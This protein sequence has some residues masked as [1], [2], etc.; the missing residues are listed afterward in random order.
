M[1]RVLVNGGR[2]RLANG[3]L[4]M[5]ASGD[6]C[7]CGG[8]CSCTA[9]DG[10]A[11]CAYR[12][13]FSGITISPWDW[14]D[15]GTY[16]RDIGTPNAGPHIV[17]EATVVG[18]DICRVFRDWTYCVVSESASGDVSVRGQAGIT[19]LEIGG[20]RYLV[21]SLFVSVDGSVSFAQ[22]YGW[23]EIPDCSP[24]TYTIS[25]LLTA[26]APSGSFTGSFFEENILA[27]GETEGSEFDVI[28]GYGGTA[29]VQLLA[30]DLSLDTIDPPCACVPLPITL[31]VSCAD[32]YVGTIDGSDA[33]DGDY[34]ADRTVANA[35]SWTGA[36]LTITYD[37]IGPTNGLPEWTATYTSGGVTLVWHR[38]LA[39]PAVCECPEGGGWIFDD[40]ASTSQTGTP[41]LS[42]A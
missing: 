17:K 26:P 18:G 25:N 11:P 34:E 28:G 6:P 20:T 40:A 30:S 3:R 16:V 42:I 19:I 12:L 8:G 27:P 41:T 36:E 10:V 32:T 23:T 37:Y 14:D 29:T 35:C 7:C 5:G 33:S 39:D 4:L 21:V 22:F 15:Q 2:F 13:T 24:A 1:P 9:C 31:C 38:E